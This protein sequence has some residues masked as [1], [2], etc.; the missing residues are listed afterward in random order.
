MVSSELLIEIGFKQE[1]IEQYIYYANML[2][3]GIVPI[4]DAYAKDEISFKEA[5]EQ[6]DFLPTNT[7]MQRNFGAG[8][9]IILFD[10]EKV[11]TRK[12]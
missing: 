8:N 4:C 1:M 9:G 11:I 6:T 10:G 12:N 5:L 7:R 3:D 2:D